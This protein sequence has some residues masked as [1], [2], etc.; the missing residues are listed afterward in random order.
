L[1]YGILIFFYCCLFCGAHAQFAPQVGIAGTTAIPATSVKFI[2]WAT[3]CSIK[4]GLRNIAIPDSD[5]ATTGDSSMATGP[6][7]VAIVSLGDSGVA[8][9]TFAAPIYNG[10]GADFAVF[11]NGFSNP[12][13]TT[14][15][16]LE[17]AFVEVSSDGINYFRFPATSNTQDTAQI[18]GVG[19]YMD[20]SRINNLAG[21][22]IARY[23]TPFDLQELAGTPGL[24]VNNIIHVRVVD[25]VGDIGAHACK[26]NGGRPV[27]D[28][29][30]TPFATGGFDL[31]AVGVIY[32]VGVIP[33]GVNG[34]SAWP[35]VTTYPNPAKDEVTV[36]IA[37][38]MQWQSA[39]ITDMT[40]KVVTRLSA[41]Q[42]AN[43][44]I[45]KGYNSGMYFLTLQDINGAR[46]VGK[47]IKLQD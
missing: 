47:I 46:W 2:G 17:L 42:P 15:A 8:T 45:L 6:A 40:G 37:D 11:E 19:Q 5:Y 32:Q 7:D 14:L 33:A 34:V 30:P 12:I 16:Y 38:C 43:K 31:D 35:Q 41:L 24:D 21:K 10:P 28:P 20:A 9:L 29:Y 36:V 25:V 13:D 44:I 26:D 23:G 27:N 39:T 22:Y 3:G 4:R 1:K 18:A